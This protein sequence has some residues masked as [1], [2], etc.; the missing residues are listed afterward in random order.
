MGV[1]SLYAACTDVKAAD[2]REFA[3]EKKDTYSEDNKTLVGR[4]V[5]EIFLKLKAG[6][7]RGTR[8]VDGYERRE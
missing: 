1:A 8:E 6:C 2:H 4:E 7:V 5:E 3:A